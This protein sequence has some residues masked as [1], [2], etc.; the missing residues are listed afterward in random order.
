[1]RIGDILTAVND[2]AVKN[3]DD[4]LTHMSSLAAGDKAVFGIT[5]GTEMMKV[6][7]ILAEAP[8]KKGGGGGGGGKG[9]K[10]KGDRPNLGELGGQGA[11]LDN[12]GPNAHEYGGVYRS[13]DAGKTWKRV[14]SLNPRPMYF[15]VVK[16]DPS[17]DKYVYVLGVEQYKSSNG[18]KTFTANAGKGVH[19]DGHAMWIDQKDGRHMIIGCD[20]GFYV[21]YDRA[22]NWD[23][24]NT[25]ALGQF[26]HVA[27]CSKKPYFLY[28]GLQD[29]GSWG[30]PSVGLKGRGPVV[31]D[32]LSI[33]GGDGFVCRVDP[34]DP[35]LVYFESQDGNISR[36]NLR[37]GKKR[38]FGPKSLAVAAKAV[39]AVVVVAKAAVVVVAVS[40][41]ART[42]IASI[43][44]RHSSSRTTI[45]RSSTRPAISS[46]NH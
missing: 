13:D 42:L 43:G 40:E 41:K 34:T 3:S 24:L 4:Y 32:E 14:N 27:M 29:N 1:M 35:D 20:G 25:L 45:R 33:G 36:R 28:G 12:Q 16:V 15:S 2:K 23:H 22:T 31:E 37:T 10:G 38:P 19:A 6:D 17:D 30:V 5:R 18:G 26:Y 11:N 21:S 7:V 8:Q 44:I 39:A 46:S 9:G